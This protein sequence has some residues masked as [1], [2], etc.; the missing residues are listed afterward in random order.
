MTENDTF[1]AFQHENEKLFMNCL[2][3][4]GINFVLI[5]PLFDKKFYL[6]GYFAEYLGF[7]FSFTLTSEC[8][9][10]V[11]DDIQSSDIAWKTLKNESTPGKPGKIMKFCKKVIKILE[12]LHETWKTVIKICTIDFVTT[13][14]FNMSLFIYEKVFP[15][16]LLIIAVL[17]MEEF[18][19][20]SL[21]F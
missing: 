4:S 9:G 10:Y 21:K 15:I 1:S 17:L 2:C 5:C 13:P 20:S 19:S 8:Q 6:S 18:P 16:K 12:K 14:V 7:S 3:N 11:R